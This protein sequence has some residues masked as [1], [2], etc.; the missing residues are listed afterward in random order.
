MLE[1]YKNRSIGIEKA[2]GL[3][4]QQLEGRIVVGEFLDVE[5]PVLTDELENRRRQALGGGGGA[6]V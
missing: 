1:D 3:D 5:K 2:R 6:R 4:P